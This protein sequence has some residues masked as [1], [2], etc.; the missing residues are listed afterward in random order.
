MPHPAAPAPALRLSLPAPPPPPPALDAVQAQAAAWPADAGHLLVVGAP[1]SGKTTTALAA[2][3]AR[4]RAQAGRPGRPG[5]GD[6]GVLML[7]P[8]RRGAARVR[9]AVAARLGR[10]TTQVLVRTPASFAYSVLRLRA[11]LLGEPAPTLITGPEQDQV[12]G[13]LLAGH[14]AGLGAPV[15]WPAGI[16]PET[17]AL[18]AF[19]DE[20]RDLFMRAAE[21]GLGPEDLAARGERYDRPEWLAAAGLLREYQDVTALGE[22]TPDRGA[23]L[24]AAR[25]VDE[26][27]AALRAWEAGGARPPAAAVVR[28]RGGRP[29]GLHPRHRPAAA[30]PGAGRRAAAAARRP[31]RRR[32]GLPRRQPGA[33]R[34][35]R[36]PRAARRV[37]RHPARAAHGAPRAR[38]RCAAPRWPSPGRSPR[39]APPST[40]APAS[41]RRPSAMPPPGPTCGPTTPARRRA[42]WRCPCCARGRRRAP[43]SPAGCARSGSTTAP[44]G[45][46]WPSWCAPP[47]TSPAS[48]A[49]CAAGACRPGAPRRPACCA[50]SP[51]CARC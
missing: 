17:L 6:Q 4:G 9:D 32:A 45:R 50:R 23:R 47:A 12:L 7:V 48:S 29:P 22:M 19:R 3:L 5:G 40:G 35:G 20:L 25:I 16:G 34:A 2:F 42:A 44:R 24:D 41:P 26:A 46:R 31:R 8:T 15:R 33:G 10:T 51:P 39:S 37:R 21:L 18:G 28:R 36:D 13:E 27:T 43:S 11:T 38:R 1:G 30:R 49:C 14:R